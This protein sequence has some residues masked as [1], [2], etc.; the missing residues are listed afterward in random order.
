MLI[1]YFVL[2]LAIK[3]S[4]PYESLEIECNVRSEI[5]F[6]TFK[7]CVID[8]RLTRKFFLPE[9]LKF[10]LKKS[11]VKIHENVNMLAHVRL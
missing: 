11:S 5:V 3:G 7:L 8:V 1:F 4:F 9:L 2:M 6:V 10:F